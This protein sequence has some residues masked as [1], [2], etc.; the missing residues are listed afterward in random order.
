ML[1]HRKEEDSAMFA[2]KQNTNQEEMTKDVDK[3]AR[4]NPIVAIAMQLGIRFNYAIQ[5]WCG[6][7]PLFLGVND[8]PSWLRPKNAPKYDDAHCLGFVVFKFILSQV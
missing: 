3:D 6:F 8:T 5:T 1:N 2:T 4:R 7:R